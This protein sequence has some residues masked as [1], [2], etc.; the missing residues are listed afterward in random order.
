VANGQFISVKDEVAKVVNEKYV[1]DS[2][3][4]MLFYDQ[5]PQTHNSSL[6]KNLRANMNL[7]KEGEIKMSQ[8]QLW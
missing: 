2:E 4:Y 8:D 1:M 5:L 3:V 7:I 6:T